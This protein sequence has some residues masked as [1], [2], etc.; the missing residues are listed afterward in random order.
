MKWLRT[1]IAKRKLQRMVEQRRE[2]YETRRFR[3]R[4]EAAKRG[5]QRRRAEA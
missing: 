4:R 1:Y 2:A 3:E 5:W